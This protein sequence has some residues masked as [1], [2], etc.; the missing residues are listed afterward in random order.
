MGG[1]RWEERREKREERREKRREEK[2]EERREKRG[3][4]DTIDDLLPHTSYIL[5]HTSYLT[6]FIVCFN[7]FSNQTVPHYIATIQF[8]KFNSFD[9]LQNFDSI[10]QA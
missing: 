2:R 7:D 9:P 3:N 8:D 10:T 5:H 6:L 1:G 4:L